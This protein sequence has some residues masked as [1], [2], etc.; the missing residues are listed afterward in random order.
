MKTLRYMTGSLAVVTLLTG[1]L[2]ANIG[3]G[4]RGLYGGVSANTRIDRDD[5]RD[6]E[7]VRILSANPGVVSIPENGSAQIRVSTN[8][9]YGSRISSKG[10]CAASN[11]VTVDSG[12]RVAIITMSALGRAGRSCKVNIEARSPDGRG[13]DRVEVGVR[14]Y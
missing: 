7:Q 12:E 11:V 10:S 2:G 5:L 6:D 1:C 4:S 8:S 3:F 9:N 13:H 14:I